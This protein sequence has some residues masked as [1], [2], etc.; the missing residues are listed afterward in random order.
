LKIYIIFIIF[1]TAIVTTIK[2]VIPC[3]THV[4]VSNAFFKG[5]IGYL[6]DLMQ[7][8]S[9]SIFFVYFEKSQLNLFNY[10]TIVFS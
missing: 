8:T 4:L 6:T 2:M 1:G 9:Q 7:T 10:M 3:K 5:L